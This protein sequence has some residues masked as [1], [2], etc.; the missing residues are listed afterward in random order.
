MPQRNGLSTHMTKKRTKIKLDTSIYPRL[1]NMLHCNGLVRHC[2]CTARY[3][4]SKV[5][6]KGTRWRDKTVTLHVSKAGQRFVHWPQV[7]AGLRVLVCEHFWKSTLLL[8]LL[9]F[10]LGVTSN[11][12]RL[13]T[14]SLK[15]YKAAVS[16][17][18]SINETL[19][20][21]QQFAL[22]SVLPAVRTPQ[23]VFYFF[24]LLYM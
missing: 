8:K 7:T 3:Q 24:L 17:K 18:P 13:C 22:V 21:P 6:W 15:S 9:W 2:S 12:M 14:P 23:A 16:L 10:Y 5:R 11:M 4:V 20:K 1:G 19:T